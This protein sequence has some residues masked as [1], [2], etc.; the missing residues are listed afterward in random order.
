MVDMMA[1]T[2]S[3]PGEI[4]VLYIISAVAGI[5]SALL[6]VPLHNRYSTF[7]LNAVGSFVCGIMIAASPW[8]SSGVCHYYWFSKTTI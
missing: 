5:L 3:S 2:S 1:Y 7:F 4:G 8:S 6:L